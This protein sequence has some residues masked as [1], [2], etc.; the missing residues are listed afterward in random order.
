MLTLGIDDAGRGPV[1][2]PMILAGCL[3]NEDLER[4]F[5]NLGVKDS[6]KVPAE[7]RELLAEII[8][9]QALN[10]HIVV[11][12][13]QE[14][15]AKT[16][17]GTNLNTI[18]AIKAAD[19]INQIQ[20]KL[21]SD[22]KIKVVIDCPSPNTENWKNVVKKYV[23][24]LDNLIFC[25]EHKAD[26][27]HVSCSAASIIGKSEREL[28]V[29]ELKKRI[30]IDFGSGYPSDPL[31]CKFLEENSENFKEEKIFRETWQTW[32]QAIANKQQ[33]KLF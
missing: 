24:K 22:E 10:F 25:V 16:L 33:K 27:N 14:I 17:A 13:P 23:N 4:E 9:K 7:K 8:R 18:E 30:G 2:G 26:V 11:T 29:S 21:N 19:I 28:Q 32:K 6:K 5:K 3:L 20:L 12:H 31:T 15:D 1:I